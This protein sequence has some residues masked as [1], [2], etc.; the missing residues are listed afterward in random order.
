[1]TSIYRQ[2]G[3]NRGGIEHA[4]QLA[5]KATEQTTRSLA[6]ELVDSEPEREKTW[7]V[8]IIRLRRTGF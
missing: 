1:M 7:R 3:C 2:N 8:V 5:E 6:I 4:L